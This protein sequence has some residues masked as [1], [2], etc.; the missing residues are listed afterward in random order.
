[1]LRNTKARACAKNRTQTRH[2]YASELEKIKLTWLLLVRGLALET[3]FRGPPARCVVDRFDIKL[4]RAAH[5][6]TVP[7]VVGLQR[8]RPIAVLFALA[9][10]VNFAFREAF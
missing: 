1:M 5:K 2:P 8:A 7:A 4:P 6:G 9:T 10:Q 3:L